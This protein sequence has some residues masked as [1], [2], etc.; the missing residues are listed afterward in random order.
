M[1]LLTSAEAESRTP[2]DLD[3]QSGFLFQFGQLQYHPMTI[4][5]SILLALTLLLAPIYA[6]QPD[7]PAA[8]ASSEWASFLCAGTALAALLGVVLA[9]RDSPFALHFS[10]SEKAFLVLLALA[11]LSIPLRLTVQHG[12]GYFGTMLRGWCTLVVDFAL[13][14]VARRTAS[15]R[16]FLYGLMLAAVAGSAV[17]ADIGVQEYVVHL[18]AGERYW[19]IFATSTPDFLAGYFVLTLPVTL[20]LFLAAPGLRG[21]TPLL[22]GLVPV[23]L[24]VVLLLQ[25]VALLT[26]GSRFGLVSFA[27][28]LVVFGAALLTAVRRGLVLPKATR[29]LLGAL[30][31][32]FA[33]SG[34]MFAGPVLARLHNLQDNSAAFRVWTW[35]GSVQMAM[36]N[37]VLGT[38]VG[39]WTDLY[40]RYALTGF[41]RLAHN[42]YLQLADECGIFALLALL[43]VLGLLGASVTR[44]LKQAPETDDAKSALPIDNRLLLCGL[45]GSLAGGIVQN[46]IDSDWY[47]FFLGAVFW[48]L[49]GLAAGAVSGK[50]PAAEKPLPAAN[51]AALGSL[52]A[53]LLL[54]T[55][56]QG[57]GAGYA[58]TAADQKDA[59]P[60]GAA[61]SYGAARAWDP[62][63]GLYPSDQGY[64]VQYSRLGDLAGAETSL[65]TAVSLTPSSV[66][67]RRLG[68][69]L[70]AAGRNADAVTAYKNGLGAEPNSVELLL[71]L[72]RLS[73]PAQALTYY[74]MLAGLEVSPVGTARALGES[75]EPSF[76]YAD[77]ALGDASGSASYYARAARLLETYIGQGGSVNSQREALTGGH[78][79]PQ[80][81][82][83]LQ[84]L[85]T[86]TLIRLIA[87]SPSRERAGLKAR[88]I[89]FDK[90]FDVVIQEAS[91]AAPKPGIL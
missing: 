19:R 48:T 3:F 20:A 12:T 51:L 71:R 77:A 78:P 49:A 5:I 72:A 42:S 46:L 67:Y 1:S 70:Q 47:V 32:I 37:P 21:L 33:G 18:R 7:A 63:N 66:N 85:Y 79:D 6:A 39:T 45:V 87:L 27:V 75:V 54:L 91:K 13:F 57:I 16:V 50:S 52:A 82:T 22:R 43:A 55:G 59:D 34:A 9:R 58:L 23:V 25:A 65:T 31:V 60:G 69:I 40:P 30:G 17:V 44:G 38:G 62:L 68:T 8:L 84:A 81:D 41:T 36:D 26:S 86:H 88:Q 14:A 64:A 28:S 56:T 89:E 90:K 2:K 61:Q 35:R 73:P 80:T 76:A 24:G 10:A 29:V 74:Q 53:A 11:F 83:A 4:A 15:N